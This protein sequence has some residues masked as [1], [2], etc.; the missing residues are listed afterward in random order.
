MRNRMSK[1]S[2]GNGNYRGNNPKEGLKYAGVTRL[3]D[4][5]GG[6]GALSQ[7]PRTRVIG[8]KIAPGN[9]RPSF[10]DDGKVNR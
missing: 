9:G 5:S 8:D 2:N 1:N 6:Q 7:S 3:P 10:G 4:N